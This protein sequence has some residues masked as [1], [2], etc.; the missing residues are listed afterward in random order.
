MNK[1]LTLPEDVSRILRCDLC[2]GYLS[3]PPI[4]THE[5]RNSCGRCNPGWPRNFIYEELAKFT[6]F[7]CSYCEEKVIWGHVQEHESD[8]MNKVMLCPSRTTSQFSRCGEYHKECQQ[9]RIVCPYDACYVMYPMNSI[10]SHFEKFHKDYIFK[11]IVEANKI[12]KEEKI[13]N[14]VTDTHV[15]LL[16]Y[17]QLPFLLFVH[18]EAGYEENTGDIMSYNYYFSMFSLCQLTCDMQYTVTLN[19][20]SPS[21]SRMFVMQNQEIKCFDRKV[22]CIKYLQGGIFRHSRF[23]FMTTKI[24]NLERFADMRLSYHVN[25][26]ENVEE[27]ST[28]YIGTNQLVSRTGFGRI[29]ECPVCKEY[30][31]APIYNCN[32][33]HAICKSCKNQVTI[34]PLC[35]AFVGNSRNFALEDIVENVI[36]SCFNEV[37]GCDFV[38]SVN[39][40]SLHELGCAYN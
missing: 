16:H 28:R 9:M 13:W 25:L 24:E 33:G 19:L 3:V 2:R 7:P 23:N 32:T 10:S 27:R 11:D 17:K 36:I 37:K 4:T 1:L 30:L 35:K 18:S 26:M 12:M 15:C 38:G 31:T 29:I 39:D 40:T 5:G 21:T 20:I 14:Y 34:C 6:V 22:H 8:C